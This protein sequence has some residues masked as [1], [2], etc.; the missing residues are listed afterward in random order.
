MPGSPQ[1]G[2]PAEAR[3]SRCS[4]GLAGGD[5]PFLAQR[6]WGGAGFC[7][8]LTPR[9]GSRLESGSLPLLSLLLADT[10]LQRKL[11]ESCGLTGLGSLR[12]TLREGH[13]IETLHAVGSY[14]LSTWS[15]AAMRKLCK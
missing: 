4:P 2:R 6:S 12:I 11:D 13:G 3:G 14:V 5:A 10:L 8:T 9:T 15:A 1:A 7:P